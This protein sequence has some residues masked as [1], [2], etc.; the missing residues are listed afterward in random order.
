M[1][2]SQ[3]G[4]GAPCFED[5]GGRSLQAYTGYVQERPAGAA[6]S[7]V[8]VRAWSNSPVPLST[9]HELPHSAPFLAC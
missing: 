4:S 2:S 6:Q 5:T 3:P 9:Q 7:D 8:T 1:Y